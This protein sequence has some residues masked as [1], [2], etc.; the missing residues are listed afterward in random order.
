M[1]SKIY[2]FSLIIIMFALAAFVTKMD[3]KYIE[4][5]IEKKMEFKKEAGINETENEGDENKEAELKYTRVTDLSPTKQNQI[6]KNLDAMHKNKRYADDALLLPWSPIGPA[7]IRNMY[8]P[9]ILHKFSG[10]CMLVDFDRNGNFW[11]GSAH[12]GLWAGPYIIYPIPY[13][14]NLNSLKIGAFATHPSHDSDFYVGTGLFR[15]ANDDKGTG[16]WRTRDNAGTFVY[17]NLPE[18]DVAWFSSI[19]IHRTNPSIVLAAS[20]HGLF[21][22]SDD[23]N[24]WNKIIVGDTSV[25]DNWQRI[26]D[27]QLDPVNSDIMY[28]IRNGFIRGGIYKSTNA[29]L[30]WSVLPTGLSNVGNSKVAVCKDF[31]NILYAN[32]TSNTGWATIG[33]LKSTNAGG[34]WSLDTNA[35]SILRNQGFNNVGIGVCPNDPNT[36]LA[37]GQFM[38]RSSNGGTVWARVDDQYVH[39]DITSFAWKNNNEVWSTSDGGIFKS[40]DK[41][42]TWTTPDNIMF[43]SEIFYHSISPSF[44]IDHAMGLEHNGVCVTHLGGNDYRMTLGGDGGG[45]AFHPFDTK[46]VYSTVGVYSTGLPFRVLRS[47]SGGDYTTWS[48]ISSNIVNPCGQWYNCVKTD[49]QTPVNIYTNICNTVWRT[50]NEG[51]SWTNLNC[52]TAPGAFIQRMIT[53]TDNGVV[54]ACPQDTGGVNSGKLMVYSGGAWS[55][56]TPPGIGQSQIERVRVQPRSN[57]VVYALASGENTTA[58]KIFK[59]TNQGLNWTNITGTGLDDV[60]MADM[61]AHPTDPNRL[62]VGTQGFGF[63]GTTNGGANW[64]P[65]NNGMAKSVRVS[66]MTYIDSGFV[67]QRFLIYAATFGRGIYIRDLD[68]DPSGI[69]NSSTV[70]ENYSLRQNYPNPF[71]PMTTIE[72]NMKKAGIA[73]MD[74]YDINGRLISTLFDGYK[75]EGR[76]FVKFSGYDMPS[77]V[78]FYRFTANGFADTKKMMIVK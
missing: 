41:G 68:D 61:V 39:A 9:D 28:A 12:G 67:S 76:Q 14:E 64:Y 22:T 44:E 48:D 23:G 4:N 15:P 78:Y 56:R 32:V 21:R 46:T 57:N 35:R 51:S 55:D 52:P 77:G 17:Q 42:I 73:K 66:E 18:P 53:V 7:G 40:T 30:N 50:S 27:L 54:F 69:G 10:R 24:T 74:V 65:W 33:V 70:A 62:Y 1:K 60:P 13:S 59:S 31:P 2:L 19:K 63:F 45:V 8:S 37:G 36:V 38:A 6:W 3:L 16:L 29:G 47:T 43:V 11:I 25:F 75:Q 26:S 72:F 58:N 20:S 5:K 71:N 34:S 49:K